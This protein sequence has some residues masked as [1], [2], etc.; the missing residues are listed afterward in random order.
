MRSQRPSRC[1]LVISALVALAGC[2]RSELDLGPLPDGGVAV[3]VPQDRPD[4]PD[5]ERTCLANLDCEDGIFCNGVE[6][7][8]SGRCVAAA[9]INCDD[10]LG[11]TVDVCNEAARTCANNPDNAL[12]AAPARCDLMRGCV[13]EGCTSDAQC[14]D[15]N[16]CNGQE[17]CRGGLCAP[18]LAVQCNDGQ[19][20]TRD[21]CDPARGCV[22]TPDNAACDNGRFC[23]G[24]EACV[25]G[26]GCVPG[27]PVL[28]DDGN[29]CTADRCDDR[30]QACAVTATPVDADGD[31]FTA[32]QCGGNDCDD[33]DRAVSPAAMELCND[34]RDN[35]CDGL[36][37]CRDRTCAGSP[38]CGA[39]VPTGPETNAACA[40]NRDNDCDRL[41]DCADP[42]CR[43]SPSCQMCVPT[44][45]EGD[46][47]SCA[48]GRD[49]DCN[50]T[51]DCADPS[52]ARTPTCMM[53]VPTGP[54]SCTNG[55]DDDCNGAVD[56]ADPVCARTDLCVPIP[57]DSCG[58]PTILA[59]PGRAVGTTTGARNDF[60]PSCANP[61]GADVVFVLRNPTRQT[62]TLDT[63]GSSFDTVLQ[64]YRDRCGDPAAVVACD[65]DGASGVN[66]RVVL[67]DAPAGTY[68]VVLDGFGG[69]NG[70]YVLNARVGATEVCDNRADDDGDGLIDCQDRDC[71]AFPICQMCI[72]TGAEAGATCFDGRDNDCN[73]LTDCADARCAR[74]PAC[75]VPGGSEGDA[76]TCADGRDND[77]DGF[78]DCGDP[79]CRFLPRCCTPTGAEGT[80][81]SCFDG[82]DNDCNGLTD[83]R[84]P[85]CLAQPFCCSPTGP[86]TGPAA[87][88]DGRDNDCDG[89]SDCNDSD[90]T[91]QP[92]CCTPTVR[93]TDA[94]TCADG[95]DNDCNG[96]IDC[97][98]VLCRM[99]PTCT[100]VPT[101]EVC[102]DGRDNDCDGLAD[103]SDTECA[104]APNCVV[105]PPNDL[106]TGA[107]PIAVPSVTP[108]TTLGATNNHSPVVMG[109]PGCAGGSG[110]DVVYALRVTRAATLVL[111]VEGTNFDPVLFVR[112]EPC[113]AGAQV[114][115]ND[116]TNGLNP[117]VSFNATPG[118]YYVFVDGFSGNTAGSFSLTVREA[119]PNVEVCNNTTDD[120][121]D[122]LV[123]CRDPDCARSPFCTCVPQPETTAMACSDRVDNDCDG[124]SDCADPE[125]ASTTAC[126]RATATREL[127]VAQCT[128]GL[129]NDCD[130]VADCSDSDCRPS[131]NPGGECCNGI[132]DNG[133]S[134]RDEF[135]CGCQSARQCVGVGN[136]GPFPSNTC[137]STTFS[138]CAPS[139][140]LLG[141]N[142]FCTNFFPGTRCDVAS[143][144][145]R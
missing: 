11:C 51:S 6:A 133:N 69:S 1:A 94:R 35:N 96:L 98:D 5:G 38:A 4:T 122:G 43:T 113:E 116:D 119:A 49:N 8:V 88:G 130:G 57:N 34:G 31:G 3:D 144:E 89:R 110:V 65:D 14:D 131:Q 30:L 7:C 13:T 118:V 71:V 102:T 92:T 82:A 24:A 127:G 101:S 117:Q 125:C 142:A 48:D 60:D 91:A 73:G 143:G 22:F 68:F 55:R 134:L 78:T 20:C 62:I 72:P 139:C 136:G 141:G 42:D 44:G 115:C 9:P 111:N 79:G 135:A 132:D 74:E 45:P 87:C 28:C 47:M 53:C 138:V 128:D 21:V 106:C 123:D 126:C 80:V 140:N 86:E 85:R 145:C 76:M 93:E 56:C 103:C 16:A 81:M 64:V 104:G 83:C 58:S 70:A 52:C 26:A 67:N 46:P 41:L 90:C 121:G 63:E 50:G 54:E 112:R 137:W 33:A 37:D 59:I 25:L 61:G 97:A 27:R 124:Q 40:D 120:D 39:C 2:G 19:D 105:R 66:S 84:D 77:C 109:F 99:L 75:C 29:A 12:C 108:G 17:V 100:C 10:G 129:D 107:I 18:G 15:R 32:A 114:A 95:V 36:A 23:D